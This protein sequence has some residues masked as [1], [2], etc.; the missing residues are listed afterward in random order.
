MH[1]VG[2]ELASNMVDICSLMIAA[3]NMMQNHMCNMSI[4]NMNGLHR[5]AVHNMVSHL[6]TALRAK[7][8][9]LLPALATTWPEPGQRSRIVAPT[10]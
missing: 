9:I 7:V 4:K 2:K 10:H 1:N 6:L 3:I 5:P 8:A